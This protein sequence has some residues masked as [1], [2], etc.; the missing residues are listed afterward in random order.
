MPPALQFLVLTFAG[1]VNRH[2]DD[3]IAYLREENRVLREHL[4]PRPLRL[5]DAQRRR[6][7]VRGQQLGRRVETTGQEESR[8]TVAGMHVPLGTG[9]GGVAAAGQAVAQRWIAGLSGGMPLQSGGWTGMGAAPGGE[10]VGAPGAL[11][12][13]AATLGIAGGA[14]FGGAGPAQYGTGASPA[15][16][17]LSPLGGGGQTDFLLALGSGQAGGGAAQGQRWTVWGQHDQQAFGGERSLSRG[18]GDWTFGSSTGRLTTNLTSVQ[19]YLR[20]SDDGTTSRATAGGGTGSAENERWL[21]GLQ[22]QSERRGRRG[23]PMARHELRLV[24][25]GR[26][27]S[28]GLTAFLWATSPR[29]KIKRCRRC[30]SKGKPHGTETPGRPEDERDPRVT[31]SA[32]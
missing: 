5:T 16:S 20:W 32:G 31:N 13:H 9:A 23:R 21:Y 2:Q 10:A 12:S 22:E 1:W 19:P 11:G 17:G 26:C 14:P 18:D 30:I 15:L 7:A 4:G 25:W 6:L 29:A 24:K 27:P 3:R 8:V 28:C